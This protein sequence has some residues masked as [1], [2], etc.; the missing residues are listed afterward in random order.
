MANLKKDINEGNLLNEE[1]QKNFDQVMKDYEKEQKAKKR[2][3]DAS[4]S[5]MTR[6][7]RNKTF[8]A[9]AG[10]VLMCLSI[11]FMVDSYIATETSLKVQVNQETKK[12]PNV[13]EKKTEEAKDP[14]KIEPTGKISKKEFDRETDRLKNEFDPFG[15]DGIASTEKEEDKA[16]NNANASRASAPAP[17]PTPTPE[18]APEPAITAENI[19]DTYK[20]NGIGTKNGETVC[21]LEDSENSIAVYKVGDMVADEFKIISISGGNVT[22]R[23]EA[24]DTAVLAK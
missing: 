6:R 7:M 15:K 8:L 22:L 9:V 11:Y 13:S 12:D 3:R 14:N 1:Q 2:A 4:E 24:G 20:V 23:N 21:Y 5:E 16:K 10:L 19:E 17:M 18:P